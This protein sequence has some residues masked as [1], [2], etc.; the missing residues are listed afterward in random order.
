MIAHGLSTVISGCR[1]A[2][3][4]VTVSRA[5]PSSEVI[6]EAIAA[7]AS[8]LGY[9]T[10]KKEQVEVVEGLVKGNDVFGV[11]FPRLLHQPMISYLQCC[12]PCISSPHPTLERVAIVH[13][14]MPCM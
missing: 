13:V 5:P 6:H 9:V 2:N 14:P 7:V 3:T 1:A 12:A 11:L 10:M 8:E 4:A